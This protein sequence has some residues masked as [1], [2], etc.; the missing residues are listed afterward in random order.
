MTSYNPFQSIFRDNNNTNTTSTNS[1]S[2]F[3]AN[4][5]NNNNKPLFGA[6]NNTSINTATFGVNNANNGNISSLL[7]TN[8]TSTNNT[9]PLFGANNTNNAANPNNNNQNSLFG[10]PNQNSLFATNN[11]NNNNNNASNTFFGVNNNTN[12]NNIQSNNI[13][14]GINNQNQN[15]ISQINQIGNLSGINNNQNNNNILGNNNF[16]INQQNNILNQNQYYADLNKR[17][18]DYRE[19]QQ[20]LV[21][22]ENCCNPSKLE[23]MFKDYLYLP[24][25]KG[26]QPSEV[27]VYRPYTTNKNNEPIINDFNIWEEGNKKNKNPN[28]YFTV[29]ISSVDGLLFRNKLLEN[30]ILKSIA[31]TVENEKSLELLNK[32]IEDEMNSKLMDIKNCHLKLDEL[33]LNL[34]SKVAQYNYLIGTAKENVSATQEIKDNIKKTNDIIEQNNMIELC[35]KIK[36]SS[37]ENFSGENHNYIKDMNKEKINSMLDAL[38]EIQNMMNVI[39]NNNKKNLDILNGMQKEV[40]RILKKNEI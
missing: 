35:E 2:L 40:D 38:V 29:Q 28:E 22:I 16:N 15:N 5:N 3:G 25:K 19:Y 39:C 37:S 31:Q 7:G 13:F 4:N 30:R 23:N 20:V 32:K 10:N 24:I 1:N 34:S 6:N 11:N 33:E 26:Q 27:N 12:N 14:F 17:Q 8:N 9:S 36:K 18:N 21:N